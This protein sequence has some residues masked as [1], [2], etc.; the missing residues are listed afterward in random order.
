MPRRIMVTVQPDGTINAGDRCLPPLR[1]LLP[2]M[3]TDLRRKVRESRSN[4][5]GYAVRNGLVPAQDMANALRTYYA[6]R[7]YAGTA[8][9]P[10]SALCATSDI[11]LASGDMLYQLIPMRAVRAGRALAAAKARLQAELEVQRGA[12]A[13]HAEG[14]A[15]A[16]VAQAAERAAQITAEADS[17]LAQARQHRTLPDWL[18][19]GA[20]VKVS[21]ECL[22]VKFT[23]LLRVREFHYGSRSWPTADL[24][25][26]RV[27]AYLP[28][29]Y[30]DGDYSPEAAYAP[31]LQLPHMRPTGS[32]I[33]IGDAP[34]R[35]QSGEDLARVA[36]GFARAF[37]IVNLASLLVKDWSLW[38]RQVKQAVPEGLRAYMEGWREHNYDQAPPSRGGGVEITEAPWIIP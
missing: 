37:E 10:P 23:F 24:D 20:D 28:I 11:Y 21:E 31:D 16:V 14:E 2:H 12:M 7:E 33:T 9:Y 18:T 30:Q 27:I 38:P 34:R 15:R 5:L 1:E 4:S 8:E 22:A 32:C 29:T 6:L 25:A 19:N 36:A 35:V 26:I 13:A 17:L 3:A